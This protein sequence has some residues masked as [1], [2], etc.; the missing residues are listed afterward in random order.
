MKYAVE[1]AKPL[2]VDD[3]GTPHLFQGYEAKD[4][5]A[6]RQRWQGLVDELQIKV[7]ALLPSRNFAEAH[8]I[9]LMKRAEKAEKRVDELNANLLLKTTELVEK[10]KLLKQTANELEEIINTYSKEFRRTAEEE[11]ILEVV[12]RLRDAE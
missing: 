1:V 4:I 3:E 5:S 9:V 7:N 11:E 2:L 10:K 6:E 12:K 8:E